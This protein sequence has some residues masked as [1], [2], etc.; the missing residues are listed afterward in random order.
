[1]VTLTCKREGHTHIPGV[2]RNKVQVHK[3]PY[4][5]KFTQVPEMCAH[6]AEPSARGPFSCAAALTHKPHCVQVPCTSQV[7]EECAPRY[8]LLDLQ[9]NRR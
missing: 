1:M 6:A 7:A 5:R 4:M 9:R 8:A 3:H 2:N